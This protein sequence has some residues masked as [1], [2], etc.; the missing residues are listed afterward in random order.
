MNEIMPS[1]V[2]QCVTGL[3]ASGVTPATIQKVC[4]ILN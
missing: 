4:F 2:R 3:Q 1:H